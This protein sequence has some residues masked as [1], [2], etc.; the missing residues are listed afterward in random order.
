M[1]LL[2]TGVEERNKGSG[3]K[4]EG[5]WKKERRGCGEDVRSI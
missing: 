2:S 4:K 3:R 5:G 1:E